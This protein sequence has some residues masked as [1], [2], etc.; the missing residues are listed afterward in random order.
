[1]ALI[2]VPATG[3]SSEQLSTILSDCFEDYLVPVSLPVAVFVQRFGSEG[4]SL[5]DSWR[6]AG[7]RD[8]GG[9]RHRGRRGERRD[10]PA[11][12]VRPAWRGKGM[13]RRL[14]TPLMASLRKQGVRRMWLEVIR[15]NYAAVALYQSLG[16][17]VHHGLCGFVSTRA[18]DTAAVL[19]EGDV[20]PSVAQSR[21]GDQRSSAVADGPLTFATAGH[22]P[23]LTLNQRFCRAGNL[24]LHA[25]ATVFVG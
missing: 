15:E 24:N 13:G 20:A 25:A 12:A 9:N 1:M 22:G 6:L 21:S 4:L 16:F 17:V 5:L 7:W 19:E 2:A 14:M 3:F 10:W 23:A 18:E 8:A 11:F